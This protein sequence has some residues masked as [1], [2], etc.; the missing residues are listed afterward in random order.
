MSWNNDVVLEF[1]ELYRREQLLWD[2]KHPLHRNR[3][4]IVA[5]WIRIQSSLSINCSVI[6]LK[7]KK[8]SLMTS[9]RMHFNK[10]KSQ[11][12]YRTTWF[13]YELMES[14]L[15]GK[16]ECDSSTNQLDQEFYNNTSTYNTQQSLSDSMICRNVGTSEKSNTF[17]RQTKSVVQTQ[18]GSCNNKNNSNSV[19]NKRQSNDADTCV[20]SPNEQ[21]ESDEYELYG[22][23]LAKKLRKLDEHQR[24]IAMHEIDNIMFRAKM[25]SGSSQR[26]YSSSPSP[27]PRK[28]KSPIFIVAQQNHPQ[29]EDENVS[30]QE[31]MQSQPPP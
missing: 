15:G 4:E 31:H 27:V 7:K 29:Y 12:G 11:I 8:E 25:Q 18:A 14:F 20:K 22:R 17:A 26:S 28:M 23:L 9:F 2:P 10:K 21:T 30:Y 6:D 13:A 5:A 1:L 19:Y 3:S 24:D 16:Y